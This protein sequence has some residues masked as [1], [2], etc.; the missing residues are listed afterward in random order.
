MWLID[1]WEKM[2]SNNVH[3]FSDYP[4]YIQNIEVYKEYF[5][6]P[7]NEKETFDNLLN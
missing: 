7:L 5:G 2:N 6:G 1:K 4:F 3:P